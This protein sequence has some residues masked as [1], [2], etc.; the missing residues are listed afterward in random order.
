MTK[1][2]IH[3]SHTRGHADYGWLNTHHTFSFANYYDA[4]R[5]HFGALRVLN[6]DIISG[7]N[8]FDTHPHDNMEI[9]SIPL[10][11][12]LVHRDSMG[13]STVIHQGDIQVMSAGSGIEHS[14]YNYHPDKSGK[15]LQI[16]VFPNKRNV[17]P[18]YGQI[19]LNPADSLNRLQQIVSPDPND[20]GLWIHQEAWFHIGNFTQR[21]QFEYK[22][23]KKGNGVYLFVIE[24]E[25]EI[26]DEPLG[27]RD[28]IGIW[29]SDS[30][31]ITAK[32]TLKLL[33]MEVPMIS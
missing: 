25:A 11:G 30:I 10:E 15:F 18:R 21:S 2:I 6:D 5:I 29:E 32:N 31:S 9:I 24:G 27:P 23:K 4:D 1:R 20:E 13:N 16:W 28:G 19:T 3:K 33:I 17:T 7:G 14:E 26:E 22:L 8:G 12:A